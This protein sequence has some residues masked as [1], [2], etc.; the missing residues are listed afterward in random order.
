MRVIEVALQS[1]AFAPKVKANNR[2]MTPKSLS[3]NGFLL[4][5]GRA[6]EQ[7]GGHG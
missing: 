1:T 2:R 4:S 5:A 6:I 3:L 7:A